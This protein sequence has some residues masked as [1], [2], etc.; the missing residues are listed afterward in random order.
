MKTRKAGSQPTLGFEDFWSEKGSGSF[1]PSYRCLDSSVRVKGQATVTGRTV[2]DLEI[3]NLRTKLHAGRGCRH[4]LNDTEGPGAFVIENLM[5]MSPQ[6]TP[7][8]SV[9]I[10]DSKEICG[11]V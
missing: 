4:E 11:V 9:S 7:N 10:K 5:G 8:L 2:V 6:H 1:K 3:G